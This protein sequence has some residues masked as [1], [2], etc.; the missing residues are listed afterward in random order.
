MTHRTFLS[1][2][3]THVHVS[4]TPRISL[5]PTHEFLTERIS[6]GDV[7]VRRD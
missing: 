5:G 6:V 7:S 3:F 1:T 2:L 4:S